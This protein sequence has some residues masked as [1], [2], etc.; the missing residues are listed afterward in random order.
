MDEM[1]CSSSKTHENKGETYRRKTTAE[2]F[3][4]ERRLTETSQRVVL[5]LDGD[6][7]RGCKVILGSATAVAAAVALV[8]IRVMKTLLGR[9]KRQ[10]RDIGGRVGHY[11]LYKNPGFGSP[12][13][14][15]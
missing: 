6:A 3:V 12:L 14:K 9:R 10:R 11:F 13:V 8:I 7:W 2:G 15:N 5:R 1:G 4:L